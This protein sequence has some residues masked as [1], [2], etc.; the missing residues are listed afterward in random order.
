VSARI[1]TTEPKPIALLSGAWSL[2]AALALLLLGIGLLGSLLGIRARLDGFGTAVIGVVL[3]CYYVG[4]MGG[5]QL[6]PIVVNRVGH[7][8]VF[9][10]LAALASTSVLLHSVVVNPVVWGAARLITGACLAGLYVVAESWL[11]ASATNR[12]RGRLLSLYMVVVMGGIGGGQLLLGVADPAGFGLFILAATLISLAVVPISL[13]VSP[14]PAFEVPERMHLR[15]LWAKSPVGV[16]GGVGTGVANGA[17]FAMAPVY[18]VAVGMSVSRVALFMAT[19]IAGAV[20]LQ[21]PIGAW[22]DR[23]RRRRSI[24]TVNLVAAAAALGVAQLHPNSDWQFAAAFFLGGTT[25]PLYSLNLSHV[26]DVLE[27]RQTVAASSLFVFL[28]GA[29]SVLGP[30]GAS[31]LMART[32]PDALF[33]M[34]GGVHLTVAA[35][36][37]YRII[38][39]EGVPVANQRRFLSIPARA[40]AL[41]GVLVRSRR[42]H[43]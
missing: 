18:G 26:N 24:V 21:L 16:A 36:V 9:A 8:R 2:F 33:W 10:G 13:S 32:H 7:I 3:A 31:V 40:S 43:G 14:A 6:A 27:A 29:G 22:S 25:F 41:I 38:V 19:M 20:V 37:V 28:T 30:I 34:I 15:Q 12:T 17:V 1:E 4:F 23:V 42:N 39:H 35:Y 5:S 11:N